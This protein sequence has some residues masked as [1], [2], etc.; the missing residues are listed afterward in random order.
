MPRVPRFK[1]E[2]A[3]A[4]FWSSHSTADYVSDTRAV[5]DGLR[6]G[7]RVKR[8]VEERLRKRAVSLRLAQA[9]I[10]QVR[11]MAMRKGFGYQ[12]LLRLWILE[13]LEKELTDEAA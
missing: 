11:R 5:E 3:E 13:R 1:S 10:D 9:T 4:D 2:K 6:L 8:Q 12:T 7:G